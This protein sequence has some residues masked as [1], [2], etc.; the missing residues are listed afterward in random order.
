M[1]RPMCALL[2]ILSGCCGTAA[3]IIDLADGGLGF[4]LDI[5]EGGEGLEI[6]VW[7]SP[8]NDVVLWRLVADPTFDARSLRRLDYGKVPPGMTQITP[9]PGKPPDLLVEGQVVLVEVLK[10]NR[11]SF[12]CPVQR[13]GLRLRQQ[14]G[15]L[16]EASD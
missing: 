13:D 9:P 15:R 11:G 5:P 6:G 1:K 16:V 7:K 12:F 3:P 14:K 10:T 4:V 2:L 8:E